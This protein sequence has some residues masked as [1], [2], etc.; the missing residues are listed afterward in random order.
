MAVYWGSNVLEPETTKKELS[1]SSP[2]APNK[3][4]TQG[5]AKS[6]GPPEACAL[7]WGGQG[8]Q[9]PASFTLELVTDAVTVSCVNA[10]DWGADSLGSCDAG[11]SI[12]LQ[13]HLPPR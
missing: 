11:Q 4:R 3:T 7:Q 2:A 9:L 10:I 13:C 8:Q 1:I 12:G 6:W 5:R